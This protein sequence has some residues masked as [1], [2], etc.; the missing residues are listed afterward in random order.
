MTMTKTVTMAVTVTVTA[1]MAMTT[2]HVHDPN[3]D[4]AHPMATIIVGSCR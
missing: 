1:S 2:D 3:Y 4:Q